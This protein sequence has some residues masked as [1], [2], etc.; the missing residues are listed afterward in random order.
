MRVAV[1]MC[2]NLCRTGD[3]VFEFNKRRID[4]KRMFSLTENILFY[5]IEISVICRYRMIDIGESNRFG[6]MFDVCGKVAIWT[7]S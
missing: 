5:I 7:T 2:W 3:D 1:R 6:I 4:K